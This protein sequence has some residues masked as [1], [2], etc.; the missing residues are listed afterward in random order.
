MNYSEAMDAAQTR[1]D[2]TLVRV[3]V[4]HHPSGDYTVEQQQPEDR[5]RGNVVAVDPQIPGAGSSFS[6]KAVLTYI[7]ARM[8]QLWKIHHFTTKTGTSQLYGS[9]SQA[10]IVAYG[11]WSALKRLFYQFYSIPT[12]NG[13]FFEDV[14][15]FTGLSFNQLIGDAPRKFASP[16]DDP[17][18]LDNE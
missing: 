15:R 17:N 4:V 11:E 12:C 7:L 8:A 13:E 18:L 16:H 10:T 1:A 14:E 6:R 2:L 9:R 3:Y 5:H